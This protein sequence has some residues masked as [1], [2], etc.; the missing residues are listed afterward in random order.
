MGWHLF[1]EGVLGKAEREEGEEIQ[2]EE[3]ES[4]ARPSCACHPSLQ[5]WAG[6]A[7]G[8]DPRGGAG[9]QLPGTQPGP[10][11]PGGKAPVAGRAEVPG[12]RGRRAWAPVCRDRA[13]GPERSGAKSGSAPR[14]EQ[15][16]GVEGRDRGCCWDGNPEPEP[17]VS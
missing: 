14:T 13:N 12:Q 16:Q 7:L 8:S 9:C 4:G 15:D 1:G 11:G 10:A 17:Q 3:M 2:Q 5:F 6:G